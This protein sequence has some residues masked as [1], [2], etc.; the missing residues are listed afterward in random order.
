MVKTINQFLFFIV[1][2]ILINACVTNIDI[3]LSQHNSIVLNGLIVPGD[4]ISLKLFRSGTDTDSIDFTA[5]ENADV[6]L[7]VNDKE[8]ETFKYLGNGEYQSSTIAQELTNYKVEV[9]T[10]ENEKVWAETFTPEINFNAAF[11]TVSELGGNENPY[12]LYLTLTDNPDYD[13]FYWVCAERT[14]FSYDSITSKIVCFSLYSNSPYI[15]KFN[16][17]YDP[18]GSGGYH[19]GYWYFLHFDDKDFS[20]QNIKIDIFR[21]GTSGMIQEVDIV[22]N[23]DKHYSNYLKSKMIN[24]QGGD[25]IG[26]DGPPLNY[27]PAFL[28]TNVHGGMGILGSYTSYSKTY[29]Y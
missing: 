10:T 11:N 24:E 27:K 18:E 15:D 4:I 13:N 16:V 2:L 14:S 23:M 9:L 20:G 8:A 22:F 3:K 26:D 19:Y 1:V 5:I 17:A 25:Y 7:F 21:Y 6:T 29:N 12:L 28:Y